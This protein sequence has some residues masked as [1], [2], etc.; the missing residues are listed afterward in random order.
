MYAAPLI[1]DFDP[2]CFKISAF[3]QSTVM[4]SGLPKTTRKSSLA[5]QG[6]MRSSPTRVGQ[7]WTFI[8]PYEAPLWCQVCGSIPYQTTVPRFHGLWGCLLSG[9]W[10]PCL[11]ESIGCFWYIGAAWGHFTW[12]TI[13]FFAIWVGSTNGGPPK[14]GWFIMENPTKM[15]DLGVP[16]F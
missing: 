14:V 10:Q 6:R 12:F 13:Y 16:L 9:G 4:A 2:W 1:F 15:D 7:G 5:P 8:P 3:L 11:G